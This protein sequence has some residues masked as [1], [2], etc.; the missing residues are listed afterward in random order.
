[1]TYDTING[2][3]SLFSNSSESLQVALV[4]SLHTLNVPQDVFMNFAKASNGTY[5]LEEQ[6]I[7]YPASYE[8]N[9][10]IT[11]TLNGG[12]KTTIPSTELFTYPR[13]YNPQGVYSISNTSFFLAEISNVSSG[14]GFVYQW[15]IPYL[16]M[17]YFIGD[18]ARSRFQMAPAIRTDF[19]SQGAGYMLS[20]ICD[21]VSTTSST[22]PPASS[23]THPKPSTPVPSTPA[24]KSN[25]GAIVGGVVGGVL[26]LILIV[27]GL[28]LLFYR[29]RRQKRRSEAD[30]T[31]ESA[32]RPQDQMSQPGG[33]PSE[34]M[35]HYTSYTGT[36]PHDPHAQELHSAT[37]SPDNRS[38]D[39]WLSSHGSD[40]EVRLIF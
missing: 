16:T 19:Q 34:R 9:G 12:Y 22:H 37:K 7:I 4:P 29:S 3:V 8:P 1:M 15:G 28:A 14:A 40:H 35:S 13:L 17:N 20:A 39:Q 31:R 32:S 21:P 2:S 24:S 18:W 6:N 30:T 5:I 25:T 23:A 38:V 10:N 11:V 33:G 26:G 36:T 27:G